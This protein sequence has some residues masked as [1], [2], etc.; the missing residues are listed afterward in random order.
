MFWSD[1]GTLITGNVGTEN[2]CVTISR[3]V[4][5][6]YETEDHWATS[7]GDRKSNGGRRVKLF[8]RVVIVLATITFWVTMGSESAQ[9]VVPQ[10]TVAASEAYAHDCP[11]RPAPAEYTCYSLHSTVL[12]PHAVGTPPPGLGPAQLQSAYALPSSTAGAGATVY[13]ID[14]YGY[15]NAKSDLDRYRSQYGLPAMATCTTTGLTPCFRKVNQVGTTGNY[16]P[17]DVGW[18]AESALDLDMVSA[19]CPRC[20]I[21]LVQADTPSNDL[22]EAVRWAANDGAR[23][24]SMSW[25]GPEDGTESQ[26]DAYYFNK[27]GVAYVASSGDGGFGVSY[28]SSSPRVVSIGGTSL[29]SDGSARGWSEFVWGHPAGG[30]GTGSGCSSSE[31]KPSWQKIIADSVCARRAVTDVS[32]VADPATG[33]AVYGPSPPSAPS[34]GTWGVY[35]GTSASAPIIASVYALAGGPGLSADTGSPGSYPYATSSALND[36][37]GGSNGTCSPSLLCTA[38]LGWDGPTGL[39]TPKGLTAFGKPVQAVTVNNPGAQ[40]SPL[41]EPVS[42]TVSAS[43]T[44][45]GPLTFGATGLPSGL[46]ISLTGVVSGTPTAT[47]VSTV[48]V[49]ATS[50]I[51]PTKS[52]AT[53]TWCVRKAGTFVPVNAARL[54]DTRTGIGAPSAMVPSG[55][56]VAV[57]ILG[58]GGIP[59][60][61]VSSVVLNVTATAPT[62]AGF[63]T[64]YPDGT[65]RPGT[66]NLNYL[67]GE[68]VPNLVVVPLGADG[69]VRLY[70]SMGTQ[71][72][73]DVSGYHVKG[74]VAESGAFNNVTPARLLDTR[75]GQG[76]PVGSV[77]SGGTLALRVAGNGGVPALSGV[78]A[79]V[80]NITA[81]G[82]KAVGFV[83]AYPNGTSRPTASNLNFPAGK[84]VPNL[85][86]VPVGAD[87]KVAL[88]VS[89]GGGTNLAADVL[90]YYT[91]GAPTAAGTLQV[92]SPSRLFDTRSG[93]GTGGT[94]RRIVGGGTVALQIT[95]Q[96]TT[97]ISAVALNV[98][99]VNPTSAG[100]L[101]V[102]SHG[103]AIPS[104]SNLNFVKGQT[105]ANL[106][107]VPVSPQAV[108]DLTVAG[109]STLTTD[110]VANVAGYYLS[111]TALISP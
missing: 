12:R 94:P 64:V 31:A 10:P 107:I 106:V 40:C 43:S 95:G 16:P 11:V 4:V 61:G 60:S 55:G 81:I 74:T 104:T 24:I 51:G 35:G 86:I 92:V 34:S 73:A 13:V 8:K 78:S 3:G 17:E 52:T 37:T 59:V 68:T 102:Y 7:V 58:R 100:Y 9:A 5:A 109:P 111:G 62:G 26:Y 67:K 22:F 47:G 53:F 70:S 19:V 1:A 89:G 98:T 66:S 36:I 65:T 77:P 85:V 110:L 71:L 48:T 84:T 72:I 88:Y 39:G 46:S 69:K 30:N 75:I 79:V 27:P 90:G 83:T 2:I 56:S 50:A 41:G 6:E 49:T 105:V 99:V 28:P 97:S 44:Q 76:A 42:L 32:A 20:N 91:R 38:A 25:G 45:G 18:A 21:T 63:V 82:S 57:Q 103:A 54:L 101:T 93:T 87:G 29:V 23:Y 15:A 80:L 108:V 14:A 33:V 96:G